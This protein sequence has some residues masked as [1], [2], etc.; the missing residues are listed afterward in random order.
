[1]VHCPCSSWGPEAHVHI[2]NMN[3]T[4]DYKMKEEKQEGEEKEEEE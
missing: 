4:R 2:S 1:M 3:W